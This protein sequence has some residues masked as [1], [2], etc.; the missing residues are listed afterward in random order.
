MGAGTVILLAFYLGGFAA[1][2]P[3]Y[4]HSQVPTFKA[5]LSA[6]FWPIG[7]ALHFLGGKP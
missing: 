6:A 3:A 2:L 7:V 5:I 4:L 1:V